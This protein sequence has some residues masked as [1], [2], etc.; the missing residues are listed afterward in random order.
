MGWA[1]T[2]DRRFDDAVKHCQT[3]AELEPD[4]SEGWRCLG[5]AYLAKEMWDEAIATLHKAAVVGDTPDEWE[6]MFVGYAYAKSGRTREALKILQK[7]KSRTRDL[8]K[9]TAETR[10]VYLGLGEYVHH[11]HVD[12]RSGAAHVQQ[13]RGAGGRFGKDGMDCVDNLMA[14][15][16]NNPV[17]ELDMHYPLRNERYELR[18][19]PPA[20]GKWRGGIGVVRENRFLEAGYLSCE[21]DRQLEAPV[22]VFGG[23]EGLPGALTRNPGEPTEEAWPAKITGYKM[24]PGDLVRITT[25]SSGG[26]G[27]PRER[28][29]EAVLVTGVTGGR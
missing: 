24:A 22:G 9:V 28:D 20:A 15:T 25:P 5:R 16:R 4:F 17:E 26:Y 7:F 23:Q 6:D 2:F 11:I 21:A 3:L 18:P 19:D 10:T 29:P 13:M 27:D 12:P 14:N 1:L 8:W